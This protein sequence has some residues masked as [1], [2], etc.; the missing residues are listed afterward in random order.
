MFRFLVLR[1]SYSSRLPP[2]ILGKWRLKGLPAPKSILDDHDTPVDF[3]ENSSA[4]NAALEPRGA[5]KV[6]TPYQFSQHQ[7]KMKRDFPSGWN[8]PKKL[9]HEAMEG[10]RDLH[11]IDPKRFSTPVLADKFKISKEAVR[12]ILKS[13]WRP[14]TEKKVKQAE[15]ERADREEMVTLSRVR[16]RLEANRLLEGKAHG[17]GSR[18]GFTFE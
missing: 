16:E 5:P 18:D 6:P 2:E 13:N 11:R 3:S 8:P 1:R 17:D 4:V 15:K 12:R 7:R 14:T 10:L 9:S